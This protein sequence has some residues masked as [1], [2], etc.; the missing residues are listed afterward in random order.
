MQ[1]SILFVSSLLAFSTPATAQQGLQQGGITVP[2]YTDQQRWAR[3]SVH[4]VSFYVAGIAASKARGQSAEDYGRLVG[5]LF[6]PGWGPSN[7]GS[8]I[9]VARGWLFNWI[10][11]P[12]SQAEIMSANDTAV[13]MRYRRFHVAYFG[14]QRTANGV[15]LDEYDRATSIIGERIASHLGL[16]FQD[17][18]DG[19][20]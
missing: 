17:R 9:R 8:A 12:E 7:S 16:R 2:A 4:A 3:T 6:A 20:W 18:I 11:F 19:D 14:A 13:T 5:D 1:R 15:T 10:A